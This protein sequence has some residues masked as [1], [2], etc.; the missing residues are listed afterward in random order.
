[1]L[2]KIQV[3]FSSGSAHGEPTH[4]ISLQQ[5]LQ[6]TLR[7]QLK[8]LPFCSLGAGVPGL[9]AATAEALHTEDVML[10]QSQQY[11]G[12]ASQARRGISLKERELELQIFF[13]GGGTEGGKSTVNRIKRSLSYLESFC[14]KCCITNT[15]Q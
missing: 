9:T 11:S 12:S 13:T 4:L 10:K 6:I 1:M 15:S 8:N 7:I 5:M 2:L 14:L 3:S